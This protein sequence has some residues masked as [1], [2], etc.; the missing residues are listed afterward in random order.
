MHSDASY[1][2]HGFYF[3]RNLQV[4]ISTFSNNKA[5]TRIDVVGYFAG[6]CET[7]EQSCWDITDLIKK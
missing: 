7:P 4:I 5:K 2:L 6:V 3:R 1:V